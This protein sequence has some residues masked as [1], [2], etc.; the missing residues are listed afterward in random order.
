MLKKIVI[1]MDKSAAS[2]SAFGMGVTL[3]AGLNAELILVHALD[4]FE[5]S[6]PEYPSI[7]SGPYSLELDKIVRQNYEREWNAFVEQYEEMLKQCQQVAQVQGVKAQYLQLY[8]RPGPALCRAAKMQKADLI[9]VGSRGRTGLSE[10]FL[11]SVSNYILHHA[12][13]SVTVVHPPN[14]DD[15]AESQGIAQG[16]AQEKQEATLTSASA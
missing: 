7:P 11:G 15:Q 13:C 10:M 2:K 14:Y 16:V 12:P 3:A 6:S 8:G 5:P 4:V 9:V 1:A